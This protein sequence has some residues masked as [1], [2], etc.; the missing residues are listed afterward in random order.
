MGKEGLIC[1]QC[2]CEKRVR[3]CTRAAEPA[4][5]SQPFE[6]WSTAKGKCDRSAK[7]LIPAGLGQAERQELLSPSPESL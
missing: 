3:V 6:S 5:W 1:R 4:F 2:A 7:Q